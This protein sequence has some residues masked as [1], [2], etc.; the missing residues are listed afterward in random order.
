MVQAHSYLIKI[1]IENA[2][3]RVSTVALAINALLNE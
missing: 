1:Q 3:Q 2:S